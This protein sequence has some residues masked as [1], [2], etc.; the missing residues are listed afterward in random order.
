MKIRN[1]KIAVNN[2]NI[3]IIIKYSN[4]VD[5]KFAQHSLSYCIFNSA[6][7]YSTIKPRTMTF[8][9]YETLQDAAKNKSIL[10]TQLNIEMLKLKLTFSIC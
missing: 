5:F 6:A 7:L 2:K 3:K 4:H 10:I 9:S 1:I 8:E